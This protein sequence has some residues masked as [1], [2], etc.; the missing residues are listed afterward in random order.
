M[1]TFEIRLWAESKGYH[2]FET[3]ATTGTTI[4]N[5]EIF[6]VLIIKPGEGVEKM[7]QV[8]FENVVLKQTSEGTNVHYHSFSIL[9]YCFH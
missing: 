2:Y 4:R 1:I 3:T 5:R 8:I 7:F 6:Q 9:C